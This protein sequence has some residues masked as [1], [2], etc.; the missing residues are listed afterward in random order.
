MGSNL[1]NRD[2]VA[3]HSAKGFYQ[4]GTTLWVVTFPTQLMPPRDYEVY[5]GFVRGPGGI[6]LVYIDDKGYGVAENGSICEYA[7]TIPMYVKAGQ[8]ITMNWSINTGT[9]PV[10]TIYLREPEVGRL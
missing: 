3:T 5:H 1:G 2:G 6:F 4:P 7:P 10:V 8:Q 9:A